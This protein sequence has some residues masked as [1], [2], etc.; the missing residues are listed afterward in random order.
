M[1]KIQNGMSPD[2]LTNLCPPLTKERT[3][4]D[5]RTGMNI[6]APQ[7]RTTTYQK[8]YFP[9]TINDWNNLPLPTREIPTLD[10][11]KDTL[12]KSTGKKPNKLYHHSNSVAAINQSRMRMGLSGLSAQRFEY[13]HIADPKCLTCGAQTESPLHYFLLCPTFQVPRQPFLIEICDVLNRNQI[14]IDFLNIH[15]R[16]Y[17]INTCLMGDPNLDYP[18]NLEIFNKTQTYIK[19]S[20]RF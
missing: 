14:G 1:Y 17:L 20:H 15:F 6:T 9:Q 12:K 8:S 13:N 18:S 4:Y 5:L 2:Y 16:N 10:S 7:Q 3:V 11:F 19:D